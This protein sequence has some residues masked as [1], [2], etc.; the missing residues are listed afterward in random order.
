[1]M[2]TSH[3]KWPSK[4]STHN[5]CWR[6]CGKKGTLLHCGWE[7]KLVQPLWKTVWRFLKKLKIE[8]LCDSI[9]PLLG[10]YPD[11]NII[12]KNTCTPMFMAALFTVVKTWRQPKCPS[13]DEWIKK[14]WYIC[15]GILVSHKKEGNAICSN[16]DTTRDCHQKWRKSE[17]ERQTPYDIT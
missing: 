12:H 7:S 2:V 11:K 3:Q 16:T 9:I 17:R 14:M 13:T 5:K 6:G 4:K 1:M 8:L 10:T 15:D